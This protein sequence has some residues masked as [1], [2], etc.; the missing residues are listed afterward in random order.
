MD[1]TRRGFFRAAVTVA[2]AAA[3]AAAAPGLAQGQEHQ[4][5][6]FGLDAAR[7]VARILA[8]RKGIGGSCRARRAR[9]HVRARRSARATAPAWWRGRGAIP[10]TNSGYWPTRDGNGGTG[11]H[12]HQGEHMVVVEN[13]REAA[14]HGRLHAV[15]LLSVADARPSAR[16]VQVR[17]LSFALGDRSARRAQRVRRWK[18]PTTSKFASGTARRNCAISCCLNGPPAREG[19]S[20]ETLAA[21]VTRDSMIGSAKVTLKATETKA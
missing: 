15:L 18:F 4:A 2:G 20:E 11:L 8:G 10:H 19:L 16:V 6:P 1:G 17:A 3:G 14:Q 13:T 9:R 21:L 7:E 5:D 12:R